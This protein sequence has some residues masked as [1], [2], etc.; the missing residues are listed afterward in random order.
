M[1]TIFSVAPVLTANH[2]EPSA[3]CWGQ[4]MAD[5]ME[6]TARIAEQVRAA[7]EAADLSAIGDL[8]DPGVRWGPPDA[9]LCT[10]TGSWSACG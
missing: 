2:H 10:A 7:Y 8:L 9:P 6:P 1:I 5:D 3:R 4:A